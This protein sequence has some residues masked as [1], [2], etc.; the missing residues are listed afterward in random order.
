MINSRTSIIKYTFISKE[1]F[2]VFIA[3]LSAIINEDIVDS[4]THKTRTMSRALELELILYH[5]NKAMNS[6]LSYKLLV[7]KYYLYISTKITNKSKVLTR[8]TQ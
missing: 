2:Q 8:S 1:Q 5:S 6:T 7:E 4:G 3:I